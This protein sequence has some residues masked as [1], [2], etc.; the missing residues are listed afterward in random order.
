MAWRRPSEPFHPG[1]STTRNG[2]E[3]LPRPGRCRHAG[4]IEQ[5]PWEKS[6]GWALAGRATVSA[7]GQHQVAPQPV[8]HRPMR[9]LA[10]AA[11]AGQLGLVIRDD[12]HRSAIGAGQG[13]RQQVCLDQLA[14]GLAQAGE[15]ADGAVRAPAAADRQ[16]GFVAAGTLRNHRRS[17]VSSPFGARWQGLCQ[18]LRQGVSRFSHPPCPPGPSAA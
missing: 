15:V 3:R 8:L 10:F 7:V 4:S 16:L 17:H 5:P 14:A 6:E 11:G 1:F 12:L 13:V 9:H 2:P 18:P